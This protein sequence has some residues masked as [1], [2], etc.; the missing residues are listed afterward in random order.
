MA[1]KIL[2]MSKNT[3]RL[4]KKNSQVDKNA[5]GVVLIDSKEYFVDGVVASFIIDILDEVQ[6]LK[7]QLD[8]INGEY[9]EA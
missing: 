3:I 8:Y 4:K 1:S 6:V 7:E 2:E 9:G 5:P